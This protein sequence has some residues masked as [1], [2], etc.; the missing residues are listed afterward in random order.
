MDGDSVVDYTTQNPQHIYSSCGSYTVSLT[1]DDGV[2]GPQT[3]TVNNY[4]TTDVVT[5]DFTST[6]IAP[7]VVQ[8]TDT[9]TPTP[10]AWSW[11]LDGDGNPDSTV[12][13][14]VFAYTAAC[15]NCRRVL[16][17]Y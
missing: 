15:V 2:N 1:V 8:F 4:I 9:S 3:A 11:G 7:L 10:T 14:P 13:N 12:Q 17:V 6:L 16:Q 5:P